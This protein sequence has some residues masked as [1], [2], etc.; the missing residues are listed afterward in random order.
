MSDLAI[1]GIG[2]GV[3]LFLIALRVPIGVSMLAVGTVGYLSIAGTTAHVRAGKDL[4]LGL[5][6][7]FLSGSILGLLVGSRVSQRLA[8]G[9]SSS[10]PQPAE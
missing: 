3:L 9:P 8:G 1:G 10:A 6:A 5:T 2:F 7:G 4:S